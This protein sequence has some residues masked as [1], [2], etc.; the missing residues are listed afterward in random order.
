VEEPGEL[1]ARLQR[2]DRAIRSRREK[3][4][5]ALKT[6]EKPVIQGILSGD[7]DEVLTETENTSRISGR[8]QKEQKKPTTETVSMPLTQASN[9]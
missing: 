9:L 4:L 5:T 1:A 3:A 8:K 6:L 2:T 7:L